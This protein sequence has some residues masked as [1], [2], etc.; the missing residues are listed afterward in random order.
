MRKPKVIVLRTAGTNCDKETAFAFETAGAETELVHINELTARRKDIND[1]HILAIPGGFTYGDDI[2]SGKILANEL[3]FKIEDSLQ[4]FIED[5]KLIIGIC[6]GFQVLVKAGLLPNLSGD[7][8]TIETTLTL[9]DSN[10]FEDRWVYL[11]N[12]AGSGKRNKCVWTGGIEKVIHLPV[13]H[14]EGKFIPANKK[15]LGILKKEGLIALEYVDAH[16]KKCGYPDN[17]NGS[18]DNIAGICD[19]TGRIFGLMPHPERHISIFQDPHWTRLNVKRKK[20]EEGDGLVIFKNGV[21]FA[22]KYL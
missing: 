9:N 17:P 19:R 2:A 13:A 14:G 8:C 15:I 7:F 10:K 11:K 12:G 18:V 20:G 22:K 21:K 3:K 5:G 4:K 1:Y 16:G 6:N